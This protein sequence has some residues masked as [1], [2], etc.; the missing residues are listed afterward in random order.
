MKFTEE[1]R[2]L[3]AGMRKVSSSW[4]EYHVTSA[5]ESCVSVFMF[6]K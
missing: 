2:M 6:I 1:I 4:S 3:D 5:G